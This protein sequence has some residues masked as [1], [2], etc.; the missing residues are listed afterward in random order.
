MKKEALSY[1]RIAHDCL[2]RL[3][4]CV[5]EAYGCEDFNPDYNTECESCPFLFEPTYPDS[6]NV[7]VL[8]FAV[9]SLEQFEWKE[10]AK[11]V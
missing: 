8:D 5:Q 11:T 9:Y 4:E 10:K 1:A 2:A 7:C 3:E 6:M